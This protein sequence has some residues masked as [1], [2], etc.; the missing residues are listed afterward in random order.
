SQQG[1]RAEAAPRPV[2]GRRSSPMIRPGLPVL[3]ACAATIAAIPRGAPAAE[4]G[5]GS[6]VTINP[7]RVLVIDGKP[8]FPIGFTLPPPPE[9]KA[10]N[11]KDGVEELRDA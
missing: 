8:V 1:A 11:G 3:C 2:S 4:P 5:G 6:R 7:D 9:R 10:P